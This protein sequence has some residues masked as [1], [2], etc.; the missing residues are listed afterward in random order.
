MYNSFVILMMGTIPFLIAGLPIGYWLN[1]RLSKRPAA[2]VTYAYALFAG[3]VLYAVP[4]MFLARAGIPVK[5]FAWVLLG[6]ATAAFIRFLTHMK[7][8]GKLRELIPPLWF[9]LSA[10]A[11]FAVV[12]F[13]FLTIDP[14]RYRLDDFSDLRYYAAAGEAWKTLP[15]KEWQTAYSENNALWL[16]WAAICNNGMERICAVMLFSLI[17]SWAGVDA[18]AVS[19]AIGNLAVLFVFAG[20]VCFLEG[21]RGD[22][23][24]KAAASIWAALCPMVVISML[25]CFLP[26]T[27]MV[28]GTLFA[29][30]FFVKVLTKRDIPTAIAAGIFI[31]VFVETVLDGLYVLTGIYVLTLICLLFAGHIRLKDLRYSA[32]TAVTAPLTVLPVMSYLLRELFG[33]SSVRTAFNVIYHFAYSRVALTYAFFGTRFTDR[34]KW[35]IFVITIASFVLLFIGVTGLILSF[36]KTKDLRYTN[37]LA[38]FALSFIFLSLDYEAQYAFY[39]VLQLSF[40]GIV[41]GTWLF[42]E[43]VRKELLKAGDRSGL[44][45]YKTVTTVLVVCAFTVEF[46]SIGA[47]GGHLRRC[48]IEYTDER[49]SN[50]NMTY[51]TEDGRPD[52]DLLEEVH[53]TNGRDI[54]YISNHE[55]SHAQSLFSYMARG[56]RIW[57][58]DPE[59]YAL[60][61]IPAYGWEA[62]EPGEA[63]PEN[64]EFYFEDGKEQYILNKEDRGDFV[65]MLS[66]YTEGRNDAVTLDGTPVSGATGLR[67]DAFT[68]KERKVRLVLDA[69]PADD[70][71][72]VVLTV[73]NGQGGASYVVLPAEG[74]TEIELSLKAGRSTVMLTPEEGRIF[75]LN[76]YRLEEIS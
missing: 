29:C 43:V 35:Y 17:S 63:V 38:V 76:A 72:T 3:Y 51:L 31:G 57:Y 39:K 69:A 28:G 1:A 47:S 66:F 53:S 46:Y 10:L 34:G 5:M 61:R 22:D 20:A 16:S 18:S 13:G 23:R 75:A 25:N 44:A 48:T 58:L 6:A 67:L 68:R 7:K 27:M 26:M 36:L 54:L 21:T 30:T 32:V 62:L 41:I 40:P 33:T 8:A 55:E 52:W 15:H 11:V 9:I 59:T 14:L 37:I 56:N 71:G 65:A 74:E 50:V 24:L 60:S 64:A 19:G 4:S 49:D 42:L 45:R 2:E 12:N 70:Q 73:T